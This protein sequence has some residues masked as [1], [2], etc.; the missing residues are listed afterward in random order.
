MLEFPFPETAHFLKV[1]E[2]AALCRKDPKT[3]RRWISSGALPA[4]RV[5]REWLI[6]RADLKAVLEARSKRAQASVL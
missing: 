2:V 1:K 6:A 5:G 3:I 4:T